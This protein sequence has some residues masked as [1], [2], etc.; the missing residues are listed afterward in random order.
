MPR[1][2]D[3]IEQE[4]LPALVKTLETSKRADFCVGYFN[5]RGWRQLDDTIEKWSGE[6]N[7]CCRL[8]VGMQ[9]PPQELLRDAMRLSEHEFSLDNPTVIRLKKKIAEEFREQLMFGA[10]KDDDERGLRRLSRQIK[11]KKVVVKLHLRYSL[12]AKLYLMFRDDFNNPVSGYLGSSNLTLSGLRVQ[13]ELN[14]D[15]LEHDACKKLEKWFNDRWDD[16]W[17]VDISEELAAVID[18]SWAREKPIPPYHIYLKMA[19]HLAQ[20]ARA[21]LTEFKL[22]PDLPDQLFEYQAAAVKVAA[23]HLNKR[24]GVLLGDVV[25]LGKT[26]MAATLVRIFQDDYNWQT[27]ILCPKNLAPMWQDYVY[28]YKLTAVV[29]PTSRAIKELPDTKRYRLVVLDESQNIRN[30]ESKTFKAVRD[31]IEGND[32]KCILLSATPYNKSYLD[33]SSQLSLFIADDKDLGLRPENL[34][35]ELGGEVEFLRRHQCAVRTLAA[36]EKSLHTDDWREL[37]RL[38]LVRRTRSFIE[39][40][41]AE[42]DP[43]SNRKYLT[44]GDG[45]RSY[46]PIRL[47]ATLKFK[48][49][50]DDPTDQYA[51]LYSSEVVEIINHLNL[52]RYGLGNHVDKNAAKKS[53]PTEQRQLEGL[54]RAGKRLMG[55][56]RTNLFKRLESGGFTFVLSVD[57]H[58][59]RNFV[60]LHAIEKGLELPIGTQGAEVLLNPISDEDPDKRQADLDYED[61]NDETEP[62][63]IV[64]ESVHHHPYTEQWYREQAK[65]I[66]DSYR[67]AGGSRFRWISSSLFQPSLKETLANDAADLLGLLQK[68]GDWKPDD[69]TKLVKLHDLLTKKHPKDKV[70]IFTQYADTANYLARQLK[71]MG[72]KSVEAASGDSDNP[73]DLAWRFSPVSNRKEVAEVQQLRVLIATD[74]LSEGQNLQD[75]SI[76]VNYDIPWAIIR[77][78]QRAGRVDRIGQTAENIHCY[79]FMPADGVNVIIRLRERIKQRLKENGEV[80]GSDELFFEDDPKHSFIKDLFTEKSGILDGGT[81]NEVDLAS[82]AYQIWHNATKSNADLRKKIEEMPN[83]VYSTRAH[84]GSAESPAGV[85]V[86]VKSADS[87]DMLGW[88]DKDGNN[89]TQ[90]QLK[91]LEA[92]KCAPDTPAIARNPQHHDLVKNGVVHMMKEEQSVGGQLGRPLGARFRTYDRL[93]KYQDG[94]KADN[95]LFLTEDHLKVVDAI[96]RNP[97][98][99]VATDTLNRQLKMSISDEALAELCIT[100]YKEDRLCVIHDDTHEHE[101]PRII[102]SMG[103]FPEST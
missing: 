23:H 57:R 32:S 49:N 11:E 102:C 27:L 2:F 48:L 25:G 101:E 45:T 72:V 10:P 13:G 66:Y 77:L 94:L 91:I 7:S 55:F 88:V 74:V 6:Q 61:E 36:F 96:Y 56:C 54:S 78:V 93:K 58:I 83:V 15:V 59:L 40:N 90:S 30:R 28:R 68:H 87:N 85:L 81:D 46:F 52:A 82:Y 69:D 51:R 98:R 17:C 18:E 103:L 24:D 97:L 76:V 84:V 86:Y 38:F 3:N 22:P 1:I 99:T 33:L 70:L 21:G 16:R 4:L 19:Y 35:R 50:D 100:L 65:I 89:F 43:T 42:T 92:A 75:C 67:R 95:S 71:K 80:I 12:H 53:S 73:T 39:E 9:R 79:S 31:Y 41:Y 37:M 34:L 8:L 29:L 14:V 20:E 62:K 60:Y 44:F 47:P 64:T 5:L 63:E 26:V